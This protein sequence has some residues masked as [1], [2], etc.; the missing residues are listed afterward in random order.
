MLRFCAVSVLRYGVTTRLMCCV[1]LVVPV[2]K[3]EGGA[4]KAVVGV[5]III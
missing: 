5:S 4:R 1:R 2:P 3:G